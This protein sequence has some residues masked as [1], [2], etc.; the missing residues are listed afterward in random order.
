MSARIVGAR[1]SGRTSLRALVLLAVFA[2]CGDDS[3][4]GGPGP[5]GPPPP[6][7]PPAAAGGSGM[8]QPKHRIED[9]VSAEERDTIRHQFRD[10]D[11]ADGNRDP[12]TSTS[13]LAAGSAGSNMVVAKVVEC[14]SR[15]VAPNYSYADL[16][17]VG[18]VHQ[19]IQ[20]KVLMMDPG[21]VGRII[22]TGEC[23]GKEKAVVTEITYNYV[24][25]LVTPEFGPAQG[26]ARQAEKHSVKLHEADLDTVPQNQD[27]SQPNPEP[28]V[29]PVLPSNGTP[30]RGTGPGPQPAPSR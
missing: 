10:V 9:N 7:P 4:G 26:G 30:E 14:H 15:I 8:L 24:T 27:L 2:A 19:G 11:F 13:M 18:I 6:P 29:A 20:N 5:G 21:N 25:F 16:K 1:A 3:G 17:L 12:F 22:A 23:V 28:E